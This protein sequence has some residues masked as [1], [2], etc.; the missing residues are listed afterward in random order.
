MA[1][2]ELSDFFVLSAKLRYQLDIG[3]SGHPN[4]LAIILG[5]A[6]VSPRDR[7]I[8][9]RIIDYLCRAYKPR[10]RRLGTPSVLHPLRA[11]AL[12]AHASETPTFLDLA[13]TL[14]HDKQEDVT[15]KYF[16]AEDWAR[17]E[18]SYADLLG[19][20]DPE[21]RWYLGERL[22]W[23]T[24]SGDEGTY[25]A[26]IGDLLE[27]TRRT[28]E[29][30]RAKLADRLD[31]TLDLRVSATDPMEGTDFFKT[32]FE[33][34]FVKGYAGYK[35]LDPDHPSA[36][37][38]NGSLRLY[39]LFKSAVM[40]SL[41]R[42]TPGLA[43]DAVTRILFE[44]LAVASMKEAERIAL[45]VFGYH[46]PEI[47]RQREL[48]LET[49]EYTHGGGVQRATARRPGSHLDGLFSALFEARNTQA[50]ESILDEIYQDKTRMAEAAVAFVVIFLTFLDDPAYY[51]RNVTPSGIHPEEAV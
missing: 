17:L 34:L 46:L 8:L 11:A 20:L 22:S 47:E 13:T 31:N 7:Q 9:L 36:G 15:A 4:I 39:Q 27:R 28:P 43:E 51:V 5:R 16:S 41:V 29:L 44:A 24:R 33:T 26:Y 2:H 3:R 38:F 48:L 12:L 6:R 50:R 25:N 21:S 35:P 23:L 19:G 18:G 1:L 49:M 32:L 40:L 42:Q 10:T 37:A 30:M 14:L 45:H